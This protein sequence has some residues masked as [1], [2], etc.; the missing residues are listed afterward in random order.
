MEILVS[1]VY[2]NFEFEF[3][4]HVPCGHEHMGL[5]IAHLFLTTDNA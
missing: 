2:L 1:V 3:L 4:K 5:E